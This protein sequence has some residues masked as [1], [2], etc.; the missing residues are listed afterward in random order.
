MIVLTNVVDPRQSHK[1]VHS[2]PE[3]IMIVFFAHLAKCE[4]WEEIYV[5]AERYEF[6]LKQVIPVENGLASKDNIRRVMQVIH[7]DVLNEVNTLWTD[8]LAESNRQTTG[9]LIAIDGKTMCGNHQTE[10]PFLT[11]YPLIVSNMGFVSGKL[12]LKKTMKLRQ[13]ANY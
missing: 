8:L 1:I 4:T 13:F 3:I 6:I 5:F 11:S 2:L 10:P 7:P 9:K 12:L